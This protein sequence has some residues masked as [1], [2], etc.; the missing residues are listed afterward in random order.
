M[1]TK[2]SKETQEW[3]NKT[4]KAYTVLKSMELKDLQRLGDIGGLDMSH[5]TTKSLLAKGLLIQ[6]GACMPNEGD[7]WK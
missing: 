7:T 1:K 2:Y 3:I 5:Y 4:K 6:L